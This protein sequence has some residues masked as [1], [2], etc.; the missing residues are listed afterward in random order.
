MS[1]HSPNEH[2]CKICNKYYKSRQSLWNHT[3]NYHNNNDCEK[4]LVDCEKT[5]ND[6]EKTVNDCINSVHYINIIQCNYCKKIFT[7][8]NNLN[9][10]VKNICKHKK[11]NDEQRKKETELLESKINAM[12]QQIA[13][14]LNEKAKIHPKTLQKI[15]K[16]LINNINNGTIINNTF[17]KFGKVELSSILNTKEI[18]SILNQP[19]ISIE[20]TIKKIHFNDK[21]PEYKNIYITNMKDDIAY[22]F[23]GIQY[24]TV[25][26]NDVIMDLIN[27]CTEEIESSFDENKDK[28]KLPY[29]KRLESFLELINNDE[30]YFDGFNKPYS[31]YKTYKIGDI[32]RFIYDNSNAK[33]LALLNTLKLKCQEIELK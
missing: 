9:T 32:K 23:N 30:K 2:I 12:S 4:T 10:H 20:E 21:H 25:R 7:R 24:I 26:K 8:K 29:I 11:V 16:N 31:N 1:V 14:L 27:N 22:I 15:N 3:K 19:F 33:H 28:M 18:L 13:Q 6:C 5:V 17:V